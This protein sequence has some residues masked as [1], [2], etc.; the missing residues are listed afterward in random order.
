MHFK[1][2]ISF[3]EDSKTDAVMEAARESGATGS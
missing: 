2:I 3:V 1:L